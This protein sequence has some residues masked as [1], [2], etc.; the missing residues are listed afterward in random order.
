MTEAGSAW[1][2]RFA[3]TR[4][5]RPRVLHIGN[6]ANNAYL[7][8]A[9]LN[10]AGIDSDVLAYGNYQLMTFPEWEEVDFDGGGLDENRP[11]W[12][13]VDLGGFVRPKWF[14]QGPFRPA[15]AYL[16][17]RRGGTAAV[18]AARWRILEFRRHLICD[19]RLARVRAL[20]KSVRRPP[21]DASMAAAPVAA[22]D[23]PA[24]GA[25]LV[26]RF[27]AAFPDRADRLTTSDVA[28]VG[29]AHGWTAAGLR[30]LFDRYDVVHAYGTEPILPLL[31]GTRPYLAFEHGTIRSLPFEASPLGRL[32][33]LA[34]HRADEVLITN[35]DNRLAAERL[36]V[37]RCRFVPHPVREFVP[38]P[39]AT[40]ALR[41]ALLDRLDADFLVFHPSR[42]HW[43]AAR[44]PHLEKG[45]DRL[46]RGLRSFLE[47]RPRAAAV[48]VDW[49]QT[50]AASR[51]LIA[52]LGLSARVLWIPPQPGPAVAR[53]MA[54]ADVVADQFYLG[55]FGG[56]TPRA[57]FLGRPAMLYLD[58]DA[59][60][61]CFPEPPPVLNAGDAAAVAAGLARAADTAASADLG[62]RARAWYATYHSNAVV[63]E[64]LAAAYA[65][66]V[67]RA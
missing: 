62:A 9:M 33:A 20:R 24:A 65:G 41:R 22:A 67:E 61:W 25:E 19:S 55:A 58:V 63:V 64:R 42:H 13:R 30:R 39:G 56:I 48:F 47:V 4:G 36:G 6:I 59:H 28:D 57:L 27:A 37:S 35:A 38:D 26:D 7:N 53:H 44:H 32:T 1:A 17:A 2:G 43:T 60:R 11:D 16:E 5:R 51:A 66:A 3:R 50:V 21:S 8:A 49:G 52:E 18:A 10:A 14:A 12:R 31:A 45:N 46:I 54:A 29:R 40:A 23:G 15:A 34:Y